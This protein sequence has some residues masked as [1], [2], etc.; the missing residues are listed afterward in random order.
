MK[1]ERIN[2]IERLRV[3]A[4]ISVLI[5]HTLPIN[6]TSSMTTNMFEKYISTIIPTL[7]RFAAPI[8]LMITGFLFLNKQKKLTMGCL[9]IDNYKVTFLDGEVGNIAEGQCELIP[10]QPVEQKHHKKNS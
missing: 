9:I 1:I 3:I 7:L 10:E 6:R 2:Y 8:F 5:Y 4:C